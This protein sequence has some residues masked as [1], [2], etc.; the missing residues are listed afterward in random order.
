MPKV[1]KADRAAHKKTKR[2]LVVGR[3]GVA[4]VYCKAGSPPPLRRPTMDYN[5]NT[6]LSTLRTPDAPYIVAIRTLP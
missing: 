5:V 1:P 2:P 6:G 4:R 3:L